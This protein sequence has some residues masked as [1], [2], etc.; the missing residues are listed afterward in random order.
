L[1]WRFVGGAVHGRTTLQRRTTFDFAQ[2]K[3]FIK[4][5]QVVLIRSG[6]VNHHVLK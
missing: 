4:K 6:V 5:M 2:V 3:H 1:W